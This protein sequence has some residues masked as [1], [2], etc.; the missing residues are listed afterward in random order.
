M[1]ITYLMQ[2]PPPN[3][4]AASINKVIFESEIVN[5]GIDKR[6]IRINFAKTMNQIGKYS[7]GKIIEL[8]KLQWRLWKNFR[9]FHPDFVYF[10]A[11][12][13]GAA[14]F[15]DLYLILFIKLC[16]RKLILHFHGKGIAENSCKWIY[17]VLYQIAFDNTYLIFLSNRLLQTELTRLNLK[18]IKAF[19]LENGSPIVPFELIQKNNRPLKLLFLSTI[20]PS[21]GIYILLDSLVTV[22]KS[23]QDFHL[24]IVG[25]PALN[26]NEAEILR[27]YIK[28][29]DLAAY[30]TWH[31][32]V[33]GENKYDFFRAADL[34]IHP[35]LNEAFGLVLIEAMQFSL[36]IIS[37]KEGSIPD[38]I[39]DHE[40][41]LL[42]EKG[43]SQQLSEV[44]LLLMRDQSL[45][46]RLGQAARER[47]LNKY[48]ITH[49]E[50]K[51]RNILTS[52]S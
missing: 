34:F 47:F 41:G 11:N 23:V 13:V 27:D 31:G 22:K 50:K 49:F 44:I 40:T 43:N 46:D 9:S 29:H 21:K 30:V 1:K 14:F 39:L 33:Y 52:F 8:I 16:R 20:M 18:N 35:T 36:P 28:R 51:L 12:C 24:D 26:N 17:R 37:T 15:R 45:R 25:E 42:V 38:I 6:L 3:H 5:A 4:G 2:M 48:T 32:A 7:F 10:T 19:F